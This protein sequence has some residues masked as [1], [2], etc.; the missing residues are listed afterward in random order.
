MIKKRSEQR[1]NTVK[2]NVRRLLVVEIL[3][4]ESLSLVGEHSEIHEVERKGQRTMGKTVKTFDR[5]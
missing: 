1:I 2:N 3:S 4:S 5:R